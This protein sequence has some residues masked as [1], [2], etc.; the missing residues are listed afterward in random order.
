MIGG[1]RVAL[2]TG[3]GGRIGREICRALAADSAVVVAADLNPVAAAAAATRLRGDGA[4][5]IALGTDVTDPTSVEAMVEQVVKRA[6][7]VDVLV[8]CGGSKATWSDHRGL[9]DDARRLH[10]TIISGIHV[11]C[12][13]VGTVMRASRRGCIVNVVSV[14]S[15]G[16]DV[17]ECLLRGPDDD[18]GDPIR[19][20]RILSSD[21]GR[22]IMSLAHTLA[23]DGVRVNAVIDE[24][25]ANDY[26]TARL[27]FLQDQSS[28]Q[29]SARSDDSPSQATL[30]ALFLASDCAQNLTGWLFRV[31]EG[32]A[33]SAFAA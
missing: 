15:P 32:S 4:E 22:Q 33:P 12:A 13:T 30:T 31:G 11:C 5:A 24:V 27:P 8:N 14:P 18:A 3:A 25:E 28:H 7:G 9:R 1:R 21:V 17:T 16:P 10:A 20:A 29:T 6:G 23:D 2:V 26:S 19:F